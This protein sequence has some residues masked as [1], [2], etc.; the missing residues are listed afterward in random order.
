M[1]DSRIVRSVSEALRKVS[2]SV[3]V[4][5]GVGKG[6]TSASGTCVIVL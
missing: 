4:G 1:P 2:R 6:G 5:D 3:W